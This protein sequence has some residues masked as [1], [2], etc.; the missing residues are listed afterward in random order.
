MAPTRPSHLAEQTLLS[1]FGGPIPPTKKNEY[2]DAWEA[3]EAEV[4]KNK[5]AEDEAARE[6]AR[7]LAEASEKAAVDYEVVTQAWEILAPLKGGKSRLNYDGYRAFLE[8]IGVLKSLLL[9]MEVT[10]TRRFPN[11]VAAISEDHIVVT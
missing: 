10:R 2:D 7:L 4:A 6:K 8:M 1:A 5:A 11:L 3:H 9:T